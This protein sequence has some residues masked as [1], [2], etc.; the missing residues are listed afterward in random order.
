[1]DIATIVGL[2]SA[3]GLIAFAIGD[4]GSAFVDTPSVLIVVLGSLAVTLS[5]RRL[6]N[7]SAL[8]K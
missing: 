8:S 3:F 5:V 4:N 6:E 1:M 7:F 2:L